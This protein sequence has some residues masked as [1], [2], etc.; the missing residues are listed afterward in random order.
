MLASCAFVKAELAAKWSCIKRM[1]LSC[2]RDPFDGT[3]LPLNHI[4]KKRSERN[5]DK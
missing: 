3:S 4:Q 2:E 1:C 5:W